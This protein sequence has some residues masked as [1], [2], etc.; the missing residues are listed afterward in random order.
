[1]SPAGG[2]RKGKEVVILESP[3]RRREGLSWAKK[4]PSLAPLAFLQFFVTFFSNFKF[5]IYANQFSVNRSELGFLKIIWFSTGFSNPAA[6]HDELCAR[7]HQKA[8]FVKRVSPAFIESTQSTKAFTSVHK[9]VATS[10]KRTK[11]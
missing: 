3:A 4:N 11:P 9:L 7:V 10:I 8:P 2:G 6:Y 1:M 5:L